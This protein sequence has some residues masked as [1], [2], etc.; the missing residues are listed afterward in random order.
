MGISNATLRSRLVY[1]LA[2]VHDL[3][4]EVGVMA[5][6]GWLRDT[7]LEF[8]IRLVCTRLTDAV[9]Q[10]MP[11]YYLAHENDLPALRGRLDV[12]QQFST[13]ARFLPRNLHA[14]STRFRRAP[15]S[16]R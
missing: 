11:R 13:R 5:Q 16:I 3:P 10:G 7:V 14:V 1:M 12:T 8:L 4:I 9:R 15:R 2:V 6:L